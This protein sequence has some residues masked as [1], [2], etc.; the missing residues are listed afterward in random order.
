MATSSALR[1]AERC[2]PPWHEHGPNDC[3]AALGATSATLFFV[4]AF[5]VLD[6]EMLVVKVVVVNKIV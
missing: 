1:S 2:S 4:A 5:L 6:R 3:V